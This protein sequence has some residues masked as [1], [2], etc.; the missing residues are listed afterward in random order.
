MTGVLI[1]IGVFVLL[2]KAAQRWSGRW[3]RWA[4]ILLAAANWFSGL[5]F[6]HEDGVDPHPAPSAILAI[7]A[8]FAWSDWKERRQNDDDTGV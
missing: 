1:G 5:W 8:L 6:A 7:I 4:V 2:W 3:G